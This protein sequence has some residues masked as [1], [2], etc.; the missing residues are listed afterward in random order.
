MKDAGA[1]APT[2]M[3]SS[4]SAKPRPRVASSVHTHRWNDVSSYHVPEEASVRQ[5]AQPQLSAPPELYNT[6]EP[7]PSRHAAEQ[8]SSL[9]TPTVSYNRVQ[10]C[11]P[12]SCH[13]CQFLSLSCLL[14]MHGCCKR[15]SIALAYHG[16]QRTPTQTIRLPDMLLVRSCRAIQV[17][18]LMWRSMRPCMTA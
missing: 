2:L 11:G 13:G 14:Y 8:T 18:F 5:D 12:Y 6:V 10:L 7:Y 4:G 16:C 15:I 1:I 17:N 9:H 3:H